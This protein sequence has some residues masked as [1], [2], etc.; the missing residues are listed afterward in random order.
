MARLNFRYTPRDTVDFDVCAGPPRPEPPPPEQAPKTAE[1]VRET[2]PEPAE[3]RRPA[4][5]SAIASR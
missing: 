4:A 3:R 5:R 2:T 1:P